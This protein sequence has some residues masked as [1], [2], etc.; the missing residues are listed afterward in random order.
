M[1]DKLEKLRMYNKDI[2]IIDLSNIEEN[3]ISKEWYEIF[4]QS[5]KLVRIEKL[6]SI[7]E[8]YVGYEL[9]TTID[10]L[11]KN[12]INIDLIEYE[13]RIAILYSMKNLD[14]EICYYEGGNPRENY[15][16]VELKKCWGKIPE[17]IRVFYENVHNGFY[18]YA[19]Q[20]MGLV[21][22][23]DITYFDDYEWG[24]I[25]ELKEPMQIDL[26]TTFGFFKS[27]M[28]GY[29]AIDYRNCHNGNA[30]LWFTSKQPRYNIDFW[31]VVDNWIV[32]GFER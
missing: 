25:E 19:S 6:I 4:S 2:K 8:N 24:I 21:P 16:N 12:L 1:N 13:N 9:R 15:N 31:S 5:N 30:T 3:R 22:F 17:T 26:K 10:Y 11:R 7:W 23:N 29:V 32:I 20:M 27:G 14:D 18:Y 28:G